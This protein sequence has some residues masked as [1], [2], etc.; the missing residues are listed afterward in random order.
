M[1]GDEDQ[2]RL[3]IR[4]AAVGFQRGKFVLLRAAGVEMS[5]SCAEND[6]KR[7]HQRGRLRAIERLEDAGL[8]QIDLASEKSRIGGIDQRSTMARRQRS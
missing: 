7:R 5:S 4:R 3:R 6:L 8:G 1:V 2:Q